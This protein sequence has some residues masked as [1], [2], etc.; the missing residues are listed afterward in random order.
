MAA[1]Q[2]IS[3][4]PGPGSEDLLAWRYRDQTNPEKSDELGTWSQ[5]VVGESQEAILFRNGQ[6]LDLFG[7]GRYT[8][9]TANVPLLSRVVNLPFGGESPFK[10]EVWFV[11]KIHVLDVK[12]GT[13]VP[14]QLQ[15]PK[16]GILLPVRSYG[17]FGVRVEDSRKF[18]IKLVGA[19]PRFDRESLVRYFRGLLLTRAADLISTYLVHKKISIVEVNAFLDE[20]SDE[21]LARV[22]PLLG[23]YGIE[24]V[25]FFVNSINI[26]EEDPAV[27]E[28]KKTLT[29]RA[30]MEVLGY[31]YQQMRSFDALDKAASNE[32]GGSLINAGLGLGIGVGMGGPFG[33]MAGEMGQNLSSDDST[34]TRTVPCAKCGQT[35]PEGFAFCSRCGAPLPGKSACPKCGASLRE[36]TK[37]CPE[38]GQSL[39]PA[40]PSCGGAVPAGAK[41]CPEC[42]KPLEGEK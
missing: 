41:F 32:G 19:L 39:I 14:L 10:A 5:L 31:S 2:V 1:I 17:Q 30:K 33:K 27:A 16:Y 38:C 37:F 23:Q 28:L 4:N 21:M 25:N 9:S 40:C 20:I 15:D 34:Q 6:A 18:L 24:V 26:P 7:P 35:S 36:G 12:W 11:N 42:G 8:L 3:F 13:A 22:R 29:E